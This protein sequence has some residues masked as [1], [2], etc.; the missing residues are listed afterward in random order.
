MNGLGLS[1]TFIKNENGIFCV[2]GHD[3][4]INLI[5][6]ERRI[7]CGKY[8]R[9]YISEINAGFLFEKLCQSKELLEIC[10]HEVERLINEESKFE[11]RKTESLSWYLCSLFAPFFYSPKSIVKKEE[12]KAMKIIKQPQIYEIKE[13]FDIVKFFSDY[14]RK[15]DQISSQKM[16]DELKDIIYGNTPMCE[17]FDLARNQFLKVKN[18]EKSLFVLSDGVSTDGDPYGISLDLKERHSVKIFTCFL[19]NDKDVILP[20][21]LYDKIDYNWSEGQQTLFNMSSLCKFDE[22]PGINSLK[23]KGWKLPHSGY[24]KLFGHVNN[25]EMIKEFITILSDILEGDALVEIIDKVSHDIYINAG[26]KS[27]VP[28]DQE[29]K[30]ICYAIST[31]SIIHLTLS[32]AKEWREDIPQFEDLLK[33]IEMEYGN[34]FTKTEEVLYKYCK[35]TGLKSINWKTNY[36]IRKFE[37]LFAIRNSFL[38]GFI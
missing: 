18:Y 12:E 23:A 33:E 36:K 21:M 9:D 26:L 19:S 27:F 6:Y 2:I 24:C 13:G 8:I 15:S 11:T 25:P 35:N 22:I 17:A 20:R 16:I 3:P 1:N 4:L 10:T 14:Y 29:E 28:K 5:L 30:N 38:Q 7:D 31:A 37:S 32:G 34:C